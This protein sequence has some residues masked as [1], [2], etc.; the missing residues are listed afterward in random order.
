MNSTLD[1][2]EMG[3][4]W[5]F[6]A[7]ASPSYESSE[8]SWAEPRSGT[9]IFELKSSWN[10]FMNYNQI[11]QFSTSIMIITNSNQLHDNFY[12]FMTKVFL[13]SWNLRFSYINEKK[14]T[15][16]ISACF[17]PIFDFKL[18]EKRSRAEL[19]RAENPSAQA[20]AWASSART[21]HY[22]ICTY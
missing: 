21:H 13:G 8:L 2:L 16:K 19:S 22:Y 11:S 4:S 14:I 7:R 5:N 18:K 17:R 12:E 6:P 1:S 3:S 9:S 20:L 10:F 15:I